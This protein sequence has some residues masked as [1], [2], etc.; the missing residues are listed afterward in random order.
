MKK[1]KLMVQTFYLRLILY[2]FIWQ[3]YLIFMSNYSPLGTDWLNWH[4]QRIFNFSEYL[5]LN[6]FFSSYGFSIWS[7]CDDCSLNSENWKDNVYLSL[8]FFSHLPHVVI[9]KF[10]GEINLKLYGHY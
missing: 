7:S 2:F 4:A 3:I 5:N 10:F 9:N 1:I 8:S 6:G